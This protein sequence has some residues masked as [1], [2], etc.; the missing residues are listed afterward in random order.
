MPDTQPQTLEEINKYPKVEA[1]KSISETFDFKNVEIKVEN[2]GME[3]EN[4]TLDGHNGKI[5]KGSTDFA[6][7]LIEAAASPLLKPLK[8]KSVIYFTDCEDI[9]SKSE[10][11]YTLHITDGHLDDITGTPEDSKAQ[12]L[13]SMSKLRENP[14]K[15]NEV[16]PK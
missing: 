3:G 13:E 15:N 7:F 1:L 8:I 14:T 10:D 16:K 2:Q 5:L 12:I 4:F 11:K 9:V 6:N